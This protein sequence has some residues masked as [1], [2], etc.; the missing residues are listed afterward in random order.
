MPAN[1]MIDLNASPPPEG[2][3]RLQLVAMPKDANGFGDIYGGWI[4]MQMDLAGGI[5]AAE[6]AQGRIATV[7]INEMAFLVPVRVGAVISC[8][9]QLLKA[10]RSSLRILVEAWQRM[11]EGEEMEK[12]T[13]G[14]FVFV[15]VDRQGRTV[16]VPSAKPDSA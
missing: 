5:A 15:A 6:R 3:L 7:A 2:I 14:V 12:I 13:D 16:P 1:T 11:P 8:Y 9:T 10:G 4:V